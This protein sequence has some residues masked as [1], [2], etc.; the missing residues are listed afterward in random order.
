MKTTVKKPKLK[1]YRIKNI[2]ATIKQ[3]AYVDALVEKGSGIST[4]KELMI[5]AGYSPNTAI[6]PTKVTESK[7]VKALL[8]Q[9]ELMGVND[10]ICLVRVKEAI[11]GK[12]LDRALNTIFN[13]WR[14]KY[15][16][17]RAQTAIQ[18]NN[19]VEVPDDKDMDAWAVERVNEL[20]AANTIEVIGN[21]IVQ[22]TTEPS[23]GIVEG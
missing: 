21:K 10:S 8:E 6:A 13:W 18:I 17:E 19:T 12:Q 3:R 1:V 22:R 20:L 4:Q 16:A 9:A 7:G 15:P 2:P 14:V 5:K 11:E 23:E